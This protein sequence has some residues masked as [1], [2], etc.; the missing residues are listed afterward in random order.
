MVTAG[1]YKTKKPLLISRFRNRVKKL[2]NYNPIASNLPDPTKEVRYVL[3]ITLP[4]DN[5]LM[6]Q[7][8]NQQAQNFTWGNSLISAS[9]ND[10]NDTLHY[11]QDHL[12][13]PIRLLSADTETTMAYDEFGVPTVESM[14]ST[15]PF[16][17]TGYQTDDV[18]GMCY[19]QARYY[20][21]VA[22]RFMSEDP[23]KDQH[24]WY[25]YCDANPVT[26]VDPMGLS[27][28][29][30]LNRSVPCDGANQIGAFN[31]AMMSVLG[32]FAQG[33]MLGIN[34][35]PGGNI[36]FEVCPI[37]GRFVYV[38]SAPNINDIWDPVTINRIGNLH[39]A[40]IGPTIEFILD[41][42]SRGIYLRIT[43][44]YRS[45]ADQNALFAQ[46]RTTPGAIVTNARG[47]QSWHNFGLAIDVVEVRN[48]DPSSQDNILWVNDRW[49]EIGA[50]GR[51]HGFAWGGDWTG[52]VDRPHFEM[53]FGLT[54]AEMRDRLSRG[55]TRNGFVR[56]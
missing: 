56:L 41:A 7:D 17:F 21:P 33:N 22:G 10:N 45:F 39:P 11:L 19:A 29:A 40:I 5:L 37:T 12:G 44:G 31:P 20:A 28:S 50:I 16:G 1:C 4:F 14:P 26:F 42:Q 53:T 13:S 25:G 54:L 34:N 18:S 36:D 27:K 51:S 52:F 38:G 35:A 9:V 2:E 46:G 24:N 8:R 47:G 48:G 23:I 55:F 30:Q 43:S 49:D 32:L 15:N 3:D 6:S